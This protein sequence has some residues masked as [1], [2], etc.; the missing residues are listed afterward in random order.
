MDLQWEGRCWIQ[1]DKRKNKSGFQNS[2]TVLSYHLFADRKCAAVVHT[3][4]KNWEERKHLLF[5]EIKQYD[6]DILCLQDVDHFTE[7]WYE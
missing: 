2:F 5:N 3:L 6:T 7:W 4:N 1:N